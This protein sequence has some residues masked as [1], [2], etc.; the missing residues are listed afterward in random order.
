MASPSFA[1]QCAAAWP[2]CP[3]EAALVQAA[4]ADLL[5][6]PLG[7]LLVS[8]TEPQESQTHS[9]T[10]EQKD[11]FVSLMKDMQQ[12]RNEN[13]ELS[14]KRDT[15][16]LRRKTADYRAKYLLIQQRMRVLHN[17]TRAVSPRLPQGRPWYSILILGNST[18]LTVAP[19]DL[20]L[21]EVHVPFDF[22]ALCQHFLVDGE[23]LSYSHL[24]PA[25]VQTR[26]PGMTRQEAKDAHGSTVRAATSDVTEDT[27]DVKIGHAH[28]FCGRCE[29]RS[30]LCLSAT[31]TPCVLS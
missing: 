3:K 11:E 8:A 24:Q 9:P 17:D 16:E 20:F 21:L 30:R 19:Q 2:Q 31:L 10:E 14:K 6:L 25:T 4:R 23:K 22:C 28:I 15:P 7:L 29:V 1:A 5:L 18:L 27:V 13:A 12:I 26:R